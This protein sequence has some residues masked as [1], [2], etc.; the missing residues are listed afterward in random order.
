MKEMVPRHAHHR[1][2]VTVH[3]DISI[4]A[5]YHIDTAEMKFTADFAL[6]LRWSDFRIGLQ[7]LNKRTLLNTLSEEDVDSLWKPQLTFE[8]ALGPHQTVYDDK[9]SAL[10]IRDGDPLPEDISRSKEGN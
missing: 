1:E 3:L 10:I 5:L 7:N 9:V 8:N 2:P 4:I 6:S